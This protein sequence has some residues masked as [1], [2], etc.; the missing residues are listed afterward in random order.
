MRHPRPSPRSE[1]LQEASAIEHHR[2]EIAGKRITHRAAGSGPPV[3]LVHGLAGSG[4]WWD[5]NLD[6]LAARFRVH[7]VDLVGFGDSRGGRFA[8]AAAP[9]LLVAWLDRLGLERAAWVGHSMGGRIVAELAADAP[10]RVDRLVLVDAAIFPPDRRSLA[11]AGFARGAWRVP[12]G[13]A[14]ILA[15]DVA[16]AGPANLWRAARGLL[17]SDAEAKLARIAASTLVVWGERDAL[18]P[19]A[20]GERIVELVPDARFV[21]LPGAGHNPMWERPEA[22]NRLVGRFLAAPASEAD[23]ARATLPDPEAT[24]T[25]PPDRGS[26]TERDR[27]TGGG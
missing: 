6:A 22:F 25:P 8:L 17:A 27:G 20:V 3:V 19:P 7:A 9:A 23:L 15:A 1:G 21:L 16:R 18:V 13:F 5:R 11:V 2:I 10:A 14:P 4:R 24:P 26:G 12:P